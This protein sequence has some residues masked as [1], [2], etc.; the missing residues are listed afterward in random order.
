METQRK[1]QSIFKN[2]IQK[3][4]YVW[5]NLIY[6]LCPIY[7]YL[8][9]MFTHLSIH[10]YYFDIGLMVVYSVYDFPNFIQWSYIT[11]MLGNIKSYTQKWDMLQ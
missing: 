9:I 10:R 3:C 8:F 2:S 11:L 6:V 7:I 5:Y 1:I 4:I